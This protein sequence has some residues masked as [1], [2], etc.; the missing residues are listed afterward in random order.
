MTD[1]KYKELSFTVRSRPEI[2]GG[3]LET[4]WS[5]QQGI[6]HNVNYLFIEHRAF[7][8]LLEIAQGMAHIIETDIDD[9]DYEAVNKFREWEKMN[10]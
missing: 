10:G 9:C 8:E 5:C 2:N 3:Q 7:S 1:Q 6:Q 4:E